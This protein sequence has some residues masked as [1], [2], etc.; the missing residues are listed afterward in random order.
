MD[1]TNCSNTKTACTHT[2]THTHRHIHTHTHTHTHKHTHTRI[3]T[4]SGPCRQHIYE[5]D[6]FAS[7]GVC[8]RTEWL[9][10]CTSGRRVISTH[11]WQEHAMLLLIATSQQRCLFPVRPVL[12]VLVLSVSQ[13]V[14]DKHAVSKSP[15]TA[16]RKRT[17]RII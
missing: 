7:H 10:E 6:C 9:T 1:L 12:R 5:T 3:R 4:R 13:F 14:T 16:G 11:A 15:Q 17:K 8:R 2:H